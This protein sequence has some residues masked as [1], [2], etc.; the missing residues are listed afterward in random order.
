METLIIMNKNMF[1]LTKRVL[2]LSDDANFSYIDT[3]PEEEQFRITFVDLPD[4]IKL[5][6]I[7]CYF[8]N[9]KISISKSFSLYSSFDDFSNK[10]KEVE[11]QQNYLVEYFKNVFQYADFEEAHT[12][13]KIKD[14]DDNIYFDVSIYASFKLRTPTHI[15]YQNLEEAI[16]EYYIRGYSFAVTGLGLDDEA[17]DYY[18]RAYYKTECPKPLNDNY[19]FIE[20][21]RTELTQDFKNLFWYTCTEERKAASEMVRLSYSI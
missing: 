8:S 16:I 5:R 9:D 17:L 10:E 3:H 12:I 1:L 6:S 21:D 14:A 13:L 19:S 4:E 20:R 11:Q 2:G 18:I 15:L 7:Q